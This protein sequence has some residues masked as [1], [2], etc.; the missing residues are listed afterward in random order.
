[1]RRRRMRPNPLGFSIS[2][3]MAATSALL[4]WLLRPLWEMGFRLSLMAG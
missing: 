2:T 1:M 3:A 4:V